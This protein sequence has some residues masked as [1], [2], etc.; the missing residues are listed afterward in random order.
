MNIA[1]SI[2]QEIDSVVEEW[3]HFARTRLPASQHFSHEE[4]A[5]H[6]KVLLLAMAADLR[7]WEGAQA[8]YDK[9]QGNSPD[10]APEITRIARAHA[11]QRFEQGLSFEH[12][13]SEFRALRA[14]VT[15]RWT[16]RMRQVR[17]EDLDDLSRF[18]E[19]MDQAL[20]ESTAFYSRKVDD[21]RNLLLGVLGHDL[22]TPLGVVHM[23][24]SYLLRS[25]TL[26]GAQS[27]VV[28]RILTSAER[29]SS[30]VRDILDFT[31]TAFGVTLPIAP[32]PANFGHLTKNIVNEVSTLHPDSEIL[33]HAEG[34]LAGRWDPARIGQMLSN[35][36]ANA[37]QHGSAY[38]VSVTVTGTEAGVSV[39]V[40]NK[41]NP[42]PAD[43]QQNLFSPLRQLR[44]G[45][46]ERRAGSSGLG[47]GLYIAREIAM[48]HGGS[49][50]FKSDDGGTMFRVCLPW[51][52]PLAPAKRAG[53]R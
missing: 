43:A 7:L 26:D 15:R 35:L 14:S 53:H 51:A 1:E 29:M 49:V 10:T 12:L 52:P 47:L 20:C 41:G 46:G 42:I 8:S 38:P 25:D 16:A 21:S 17:A 37:V 13:V 19:A 30:M 4:L 6:A 31:Q 5:D 27:K 34:P 44:D 48:A 24:A 3:V 22:R 23:S 39:E 50:E 32:E 40:H 11:A 18:G 9:S 33:F 36:V 45:E 28:A 2:E